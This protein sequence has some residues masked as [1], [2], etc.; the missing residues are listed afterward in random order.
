MVRVYLDWNVFSNLKKHNKNKEAYISL[1]GNLSK[2][3]NKILI[4]YTSAHLTDLIPSYKA[5]E[6]GRIETI[7]DLKYLSELTNQCCI[8]YDYKTQSTFPAKN[9]I[10][11]YFEQLIENEDIISCNFEEL[12]TQ[13]SGLGI[14]GIFESLI[15]TLKSLPSGLENVT[16][17]NISPKFQYLKDAFGDT[18]SHNSYYDLLNDTLKFISQY[19]KNPKVYRQLRNVSLVELKLTHDYT[20]SKKPLNDISKNLQ[21]SIINKTF[22]EFVD[23]NIGIYFKGKNPSRFDYFTNYYLFLDFLGYYKDK[24]FKNLVQDSFH[25]YYGVRFDVFQ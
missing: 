9:D 10:F 11:E 6:N 14:D 15:T 23:Q 25:A 7:A 17:E 4:P 22:K 18:I 24:E 12:F 13:F 5:S 21:T 8:S 19:S 2:N 20:K 1:N 16:F 3:K